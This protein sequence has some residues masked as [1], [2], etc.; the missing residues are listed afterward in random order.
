MNMMVIMELQGRRTHI[1]CFCVHDY[2]S[3]ECKWPMVAALATEHPPTPAPKRGGLR[4]FSINS[5]TE[6]QFNFSSMRGGGWE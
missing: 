6:I 5:R 3:C 4:K 1:K 2:R